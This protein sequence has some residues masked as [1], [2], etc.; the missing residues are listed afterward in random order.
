MAGTA[1][2]GV[3]LP[4]VAPERGWEGVR[5]TRQP[6]KD[7]PFLQSAGGCSGR[8]AVFPL[9]SCPKQTHIP[10]KPRM[11]IQ[12]NQL[13]FQNLNGGN[14]NNPQPS[15]FPVLHHLS[16][17]HGFGQGT[18]VLCS[19]LYP[20]AHVLTHRNLDAE[21]LIGTLGCW[22]LGVFLCFSLRSL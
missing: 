2:A 5:G 7:L 10:A 18:K 19:V 15:P 11:V 17:I 21:E 14:K 20:H 4:G 13:L 1:Q 12:S 22:C 3:P 8:G 9:E 6:G 16:S